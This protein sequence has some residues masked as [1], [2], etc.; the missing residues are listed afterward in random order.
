M[1]PV[2]VRE[3]R[4]EA[5]RA[6]TYWLRLLG[7]GALLAVGVWCLMGQGGAITRGGDLF[8]RL[9]FTLF[10]SIWI[11]V[12]LVTADCLSRER[13]E[14]TLGLLF[15][16]P[17]TARSVVLAKAFAQGLRALTLCLAV[18]PVVTLPFLIGGVAWQEAAMSVA[19]NASLFCWCLAA[20]LLAS[21][22]AKVWLRSLAL[23]MT[24]AFILGCLFAFLNCLVVRAVT[25]PFLPR[26]WGDEWAWEEVFQGAFVLATDY[27]HT[28]AHLASLGRHVQAAVLWGTCA[29]TVFSLIALLI[30]AAWAARNVRRGWQEEPLSARQ[31]WWQRTFCTPVF[32]LRF[33]KQWMRWK[34]ELN[35]I[36][37][38]E[39]RTWRARLVTWSWLAVMIA[40]LSF[41]LSEVTSAYGTFATM[42]NLFSWLLA[43]SMAMSAA[44]SFRRERESGVLELLLVSPLRV[45]E[46]IGGRLRGI[47]GQFI[48]AIVFLFA[49]W[50]YL[51]SAFGRYDSRKALPMTFF[52]MSFAVLPVV[53]LYYSL[54]FS[55]FITAFVWTVGIGLLA[56]LGLG[57]LGTAGLLLLSDEST[58]AFGAGPS[59]DSWGQNF[60]LLSLLAQL[61]VGAVLATWL[62]RSLE[63]RTFN[64]QRVGA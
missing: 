42:E 41:G 56:P 37:W 27:D 39:Q 2:I 26:G 17:L 40:L 28:W 59:R 16:T 36:G 61:V 1:L 29:S 62:Y 9:H 48:P 22:R 7:A 49:T 35:P 58:N 10:C 30:G 11:L 53:G 15:L 19:I 45:G 24:L 52:M 21:S 12:P 25:V 50:L 63:R 34:L 47:W 44:G 4:A 3:L 18:L 51:E 32:W 55:H 31:V 46:I 8:A 54:R 6:S 57:G 33:F 38:L 5:R 20:G 23:A 14:G 43:G 60:N 64:F 13:R